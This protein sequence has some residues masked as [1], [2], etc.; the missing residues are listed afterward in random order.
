MRVT[1]QQKLAKSGGFGVPSIVGR[2]SHPGTP[3]TF[4]TDRKTNL[5][6]PVSMGTDDAKGEG[7]SALASTPVPSICDWCGSGPYKG[8][9]GLNVHKRAKHNDRFHS[10]HLS[11][12]IKKRWESE[13]VHLLTTSEAHLIQ[14]N[15]IAEINDVL[16]MLW[17]HRS[18][19]VIK[20]ER[21]S[22]EYDKLLAE[23]MSRSILVAIREEVPI[24]SGNIDQ[25]SAEDTRP[26]VHAVREV[27]LTFHKLLSIQDVRI[28]R[29]LEA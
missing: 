24:L 18:V 3:V 14:S 26:A 27:V 9:A 25:P 4:T 23:I 16:H 2:T 19:E 13:E 12:T 20:A 10:E 15:N 5:Q 11:S 7:A 1:Q 22:I 21:K 28:D 29:F 8:L 6:V 17:P